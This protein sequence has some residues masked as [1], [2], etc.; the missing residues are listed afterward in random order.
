MAKEKSYAERKKIAEK[1]AMADELSAISRQVGQLPPQAIEL[2]EAVLGAIMLEKN[3]LLNI[4]G[5]LSPESFYHDAHQLIYAAALELSAN[6]QPV[7]LYTIGDQLK[8]DGNL[9]AVG[10]MNYLTELTMRVSSAT[11][12]D[13]HAKIVAQKYIQRQLITASSRIQKDAFSDEQ[14]VNELVNSA[15]KAI[16]EI[17]EG[18]VRRDV[19]SSQDIVARAMQVI[20]E[21]SKRPD[22]M[23]GVPTGF[24][25]IDRLTLGWQLSDLIIIAARPS[26]GKTAFVLTMARNI[27]LDHKK[28]VAFFSLEMSSTQLMMRLLI[29][30]SQLESKK[31]KSGKL[32]PDEWKQLEGAARPLSKAQLYIDDTPAL[33][34]YEFRSKARRLKRNHNVELIVIDYLQLMTAGTADSRGNRE[35]EV[36]LISR[37]LKAIAKE[38]DVPIIALSQLN[39]SVESRGG[40]KR[41]QLSDLRESGS[42]EQDADIVAFIHRPEY[43][44]LTETEEGTPTAGLAEII[45]AKHRNGEVR[46]EKLRFRHEQ[47]KFVDWDDTGFGS[48]G[49]PTAGLVTTYST[50]D[51]SSFSA[52]DSTGMDALSA[53]Q[54]RIEMAQGTNPSY[55]SALTPADTDD[56][57]PY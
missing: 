38:L 18:N 5:L 34:V 6:I 15:E 12:L 10:G 37:S 27:A 35:Q 8:R 54:G 55:G 51:S 28:T 49:T 53:S 1:K 19:L 24:T 30:E 21:A 29:A 52:I 4:Q 45:F 32:S 31:I 22:G 11:H 43:F 3:A 7:D 26:M 23:T 13:Y 9:A 57:V 50:I 33:S 41:P 14:D 47:A 20:E 2:E 46:T 44:G 17:A 25:D 39:R 36:A 42:I 48:I 16:F 56:F 40:S